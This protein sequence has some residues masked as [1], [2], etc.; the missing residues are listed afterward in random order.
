[1]MAYSLF[2]PPSSL[3]AV[4]TPPDLASVV[5]FVTTGF[6]ENRFDAAVYIDQA[7]TQAYTTFSFNHG[8]HH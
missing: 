3:S 7:N 4:L 8:R 6:V 5:N 1:M 2:W